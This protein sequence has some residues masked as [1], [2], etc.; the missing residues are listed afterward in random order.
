MTSY[1]LTL[2]LTT[3]PEMPHWLRRVPAT[4]N[5]ASLDDQK[6]LHLPCL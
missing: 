5:I 3:Y 4:A 1:E 2:W 6:P